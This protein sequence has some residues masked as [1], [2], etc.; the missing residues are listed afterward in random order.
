[1]KKYSIEELKARFAHFGFYWERQ[2]IHIIGIRKAKGK[3]DAF[4]DAIYLVWGN[5]VYCYS[6]TT[7][8]GVHWLQ[9]LMNSEGTA[10]VKADEQYLDV[11]KKGL[12][13]GKEALI[14]AHNLKVYRDKDLD[15][16]AETEGTVFLAGPE[17]RIDI[18]GTGPTVV[19]VIIGAWSAGCQ[20]LN[21]PEQYK[22]FIALCKKSWQKF[23]T[24][25]LL[26]E[27]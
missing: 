14:Q 11:F 25:T 1:M 6:C 16:L 21:N 17:C 9:K 19:S 10:V 24:Y 26:N 15:T 5:S 18:H 4:D 2:H 12:H 8:P 3:P 13:K 22:E 23:F 20:V 27:F 7:E